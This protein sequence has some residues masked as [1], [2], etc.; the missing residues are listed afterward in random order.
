[1][2]RVLF[3]CSQNRLRSPTA[4]QLYASTTTLKVR[5]AGVYIGAKTPLTAELIEWADVVFVME[6]IHQEK[7]LK[8]FRK[9]ANNKQ[10]VCLNI[11]YK[12]E[13]MSPELI[14]ILTDK[15]SPYLGSPEE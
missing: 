6:K 7:L 1:M 9:A 4:E 2:K 11:E 15:L 13:Y 5:S 8:L 3:I 14:R 10:L 12:Y